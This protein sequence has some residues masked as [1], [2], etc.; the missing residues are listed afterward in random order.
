MK[1]EFTVAGVTCSEVLAD[2]SSFVD[3]DLPAERV[4]QLKAHVAGCDVCERFGGDF[5]AAIAALRSMGTP[6]P[7][8][9]EVAARLSDA[10]DAKLAE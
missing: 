10:L 5:T 3:G 1:G 7:L 8:D 9:A 2:L 4:A 6:A